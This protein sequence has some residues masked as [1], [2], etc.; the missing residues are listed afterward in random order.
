MRLKCPWCG[1][2]DQQTLGHFAAEEYPGYRVNF[3]RKCNGY[4]K[5][6]TEKILNRRHIPTVDNLWTLELDFQA[7]REG[8]KR[9]EV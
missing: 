1:N 4:I 7:E 6:T 5:A 9:P 8:F 2:D 3:C